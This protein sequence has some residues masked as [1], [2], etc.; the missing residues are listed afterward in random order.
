MIERAKRPKALLS[1]YVCT[2]PASPHLIHCP[3]AAHTTTPRPHTQP[4]A[5]PIA[6]MSE[7]FNVH[8]D[9]LYQAPSAAS[10]DVIAEG[11]YLG[12]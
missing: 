3:P 9:S 6:N 7:L 1:M 12:K 11:L 10:M 2:A 5:I 8:D 4:P